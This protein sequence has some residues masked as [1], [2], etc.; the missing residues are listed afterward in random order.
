MTEQTRAQMEQTTPA[1]WLE[2]LEIFRERFRLGLIDESKFKE[3]LKSFQ[4][5]DGMGHIWMPGATSNQW[6]RWDRTKWTSAP[7][8]QQLAASNIPVAI[9]LAWNPQVVAPIELNATQIPAEIVRAAPEPP[10]VVRDAGTSV[11][12][13]TPPPPMPTPVAPPPPPPPA[14]TAPPP[15]SPMTRATCPHCG[16]MYIAPAR[17]CP[18]CGE[19][20]TSEKKSRRPT[21]LPERGV[22]RGRPKPTD[23]PR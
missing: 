15:P 12:T 8:P 21:D 11:P 5:S 23:L 19:P 22:T 4:F 2:R 18:N 16:Q 6:Y 13:N 10:R 17:F 3:I 14:M 1:Q 7:P 9:A 20:L